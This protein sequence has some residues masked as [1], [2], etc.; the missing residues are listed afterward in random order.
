MLYEL[1]TYEVF[2]GKM[3]SL[4]RRFAE[5]T[6]PLWER[7]GVRII[8]FWTTVVGTSH[9]ELVYILAFENMAQREAIWTMFKSD[10]EWLEALAESEKDGVLVK[11]ISN[12]FMAPT[13]Y[14]PLK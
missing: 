11:Q 5:V 8:G 6:V 10:P 14:S 3:E 4:H 7:L 1:R 12:S 2:P 13:S 9:N